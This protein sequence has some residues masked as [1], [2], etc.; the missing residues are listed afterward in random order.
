MYDV[1]GNIWIDWLQTV[2]K[3]EIPSGKD[4]GYNELIIPTADTVR[5]AYWMN[6]MIKYNQHVLYTGPTGTAKTIGIMNELA[7]NYTNDKFGNIKTVF[8][9]QTSAN[10]IQMMIEA[11]MTTRRGKKGNFGPEE[12][13]S[14]MIIFIDDVNMPLKEVFGAQPPIEIMRI[15]LDKG[16]WYDLE[17]RETKA[18][19]DMLFMCTMGPP[20]L[21]RNM[22]TMRFLR[23]FFVLYT[24][25]FDQSSLTTIFSSILDWYFKNLNPK[26]PNNIMNLKDNIIES[27]IE[28]YGKIKT[29]K[30]LFP[31]PSKS[32]YSYNMRD[33]SKIFQ[34]MTNANFKSFQNEDDF[35]KLWAHECQRVF[36]DR[37]IS[38]DDQNFFTDNILKRVIA[39]NF[40]KQWSEIVK[41]E[42]LLWGSFIPTMYPEG[43]TTKKPISNV[44]C[45][46][47]NRKNLQKYS[48]EFLETYNEMVSTKLNLV[49]F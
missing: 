25:P 35:I 9:G 38:T 39:N 45:E 41:F 32:H 5:N 15:W 22:L 26:L 8:S 23:H 36:M 30:E 3:W 20:S 29:S 14:R 6:N 17:T 37:L 19:H 21:G 18:L 48:D 28:V 24:E 44:Y 2:P 31:I 43:D 11:K 33:I 42:P 13:K 4:T 34:G 49:L 1:R 10:Q 27:T 46:L 40:K 16:F 7:K 12:G 47:V